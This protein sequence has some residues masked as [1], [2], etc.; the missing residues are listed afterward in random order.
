M[1][2]FPV[3]DVYGEFPFPVTDVNRSGPSLSRCEQ[4]DPDQIH[5]GGRDHADSEPFHDEHGATPSI[6]PPQTGSVGVAASNT[7]AAGSTSTGSTVRHFQNKHKKDLEEGRLGSS[8]PSGG[9]SKFQY[10][11]PKMREGLAR[12]VAAAEQPFTFRDDIRFEYFVKNYLN[13]EFSKVSRN[14]TRSDCL[15]AFGKTRKE[16]I[17]EIKKFDSTISF[18]SDMWS[19]INDLGYICVTAHFIDS[20]WTLNKRII[21]FRLIE[22]PHNANQIFQSISGVFREFEIV[23]KVFSIM[24]DNHTANTAAIELLKVNMP[25]LRSSQFFHMRCV[26]HI[27]NLVVQDGLESI[28]PQLKKIR[29]ALLFIATSGVR[30]QDFEALCKIYNVKPKRIKLD[31]KIRW[32]STYIMLKSCRKHTAVITAFVNAWSDCGL[33]DSDWIIAFEFMK[34]LKVFYVATCALLGVRYPT[35][36]L[37]LNHLYNIS[38]TFNSYRTETNFIA[39]C[40]EMESKFR[41]YFENMPKIFIVAAVMDP[42]IKLEAV[43]MLLEGISDNLMIRLPSRLEVESLLTDLYASYESKFASTTTTTSTTT[44]PLPSTNSNDPSWSLISKKGKSASSRSELVKYLEIEHL[45][46]NDDLENFD[47]L[48][49]WRKNDRTFPIL[50]IM[51]RDVLTAHVSSVASESAF[52]AGKRV[53]DEKRSRLAPDILDCLLCVKEWEDAR[54]G[55]QK[56]SAKDEF[57]DYFSDSDI[58]G[59]D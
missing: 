47:I 59:D 48:Q 33:T 34:F 56:R 5:L 37:V 2:S 46:E 50:S 16:M 3:T 45:T 42:R 9:L 4:M 17:T 8:G 12:Y 35:S 19:G 44:V 31:M 13:P 41:K 58:D 20:S 26:C 18:T 27:I 11:K 51:A 38:F 57:R 53:L 1:R 49:W 28:A 25:N 39:A 54:L 43:H 15:V 21:A 6:S 14:T 10:S 29:S 24:F 32:N 23:D 55:I 40:I 52:S 30:R 7:V 36:C 22:H